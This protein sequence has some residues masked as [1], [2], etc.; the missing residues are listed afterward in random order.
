VILVD[1]TCLVYAVG[2]DP[3]RRASAQALIDAVLRG[4]ITARTTS[5]V[6]MEFAHV[7]GR[8]RNR[9]DAA[10]LA[11]DFSDLLGP[12]EPTTAPDVSTAVTLWQENPQIGTFDALLLAVAVRTGAEAIVSEDVGLTGVGIVPVLTAAEA[13]CTLV[14]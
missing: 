10:S 3:D 12:L 1:T 2:D 7:R 13:V 8:R 9:K 5:Q 6:I 4:T 11:R 14:R